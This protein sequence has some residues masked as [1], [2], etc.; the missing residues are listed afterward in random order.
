MI[1]LIAYCSDSTA[2]LSGAVPADLAGILLQSRRHNRSRSITGF[3]ACRAGSYLGVIEGDSAD[4]ESLLVRLK[5]DSRHQNLT[6]LVDDVHRQSR[7]YE[8]WRLET[9]TGSPHLQAV[10]R[11]RDEYSDSINELSGPLR[12]SLE[13]FFSRSHIESPAVER[14]GH[15][16]A[17]FEFRIDALPLKSSRFDRLPERLLILAPLLRDWHS[18]SRLVAVSGLGREFVEDT[19]NHPLIKSQLK[20]RSVDHSGAK[21]LVRSRLED[22]LRQK[23][24]RSKVFNFFS[25]YF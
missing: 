14:P 18:I 9:T 24:V 3:L 21:S 16:E 13:P 6:L 25:K 22:G 1:R 2:S 5:S 19:I 4:V 15:G 11:F 12:Q 23:P 8:D 20:K 7:L 17:S 10:R